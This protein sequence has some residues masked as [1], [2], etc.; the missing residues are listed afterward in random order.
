MS[1][2]GTEAES[3]IR[4]SRTVH[5]HG[6]RTRFMFRHVHVY[7]IYGNGARAFLTLGGA[8]AQRG[9]RYLVRVCVCVC[10]SVHLLPR[11]QRLRA[12]T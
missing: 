9:L 1:A 3:D 4:V 11:F 7:T 6:S 10:L 2:K 8:H 5:V 12:T